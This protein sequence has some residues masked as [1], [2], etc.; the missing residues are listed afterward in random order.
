[1]IHI[2]QAYVGKC[3]SKKGI[4]VVKKWGNGE[5][6]RQVEN[7]QENNKLKPKCKCNYIRCGD[8]Q[9]FLGVVSVLHDEKLLEIEC[10]TV[11]KYLTL[12]NVQLKMVN[13]I[14]LKLHVFANIKK[15]KY[16]Y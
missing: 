15:T 16:L 12:Q 3:S 11:W 7:K 13:M 2:S 8:N 6:V 14:N 10:T 4:T 9:C 1:M 5:N